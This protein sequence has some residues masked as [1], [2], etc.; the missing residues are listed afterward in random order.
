M[1]VVGLGIERMKLQSFLANLPTAATRETSDGAQATIK[2]LGTPL[3]IREPR[4]EPAA[5][6]VSPT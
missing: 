2:E 1:K 4:G 5:R 3:G 6:R